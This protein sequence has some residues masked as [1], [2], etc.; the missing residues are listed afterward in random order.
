MMLKD[1]SA[2]NIQ[3]LLGY[4]VLIDTLSFDFYEEGVPWQ[5]YG[6]FCRHFIAPLLLMSN[7]DVRMG[8]ISQLF[9][10]GIPLDYAS[11]ILQNRGGIFAKLHINLHAKA[12]LRH[13][14]DGHYT[15]KTKKNSVLSKS[16]YISLAQGMLD[17]IE[18][19]T[20]PNHSTEWG[21][22]Y[23]SN[24]YTDIS[25]KGKKTIV[26]NFLD[27]CEKI[28]NV[29]DF[30]ANDGTYSRI[31]LSK[32]ANVVAFDIDSVAVERNYQEVKRKRENLLPLIF[33]MTTPSPSIGF[34]N[35]ERLNISERQKPDCVMMLAVIHHLAI[36]NNLP[37]NLIV[38]WLSSI[39]NYLIIEFVPKEDSQVKVLLATRIDIFPNYHEIHF[40]E[41]FK[42]K[43]NLLAKEYIPESK[44]TLYL[45]KLSN[46]D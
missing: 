38:D 36:S 13:N 30:G 16:A 8:K 22:Y 27:K 19:L 37:F 45:F 15:D 34:G 33:D 40:E 7:I 5:A 41:V 21:D 44:R 12:I 1:A 20:A 26:S 29:W 3:F 31:A 17:G 32:G 10:D 9:I 42:S 25:N 18:K 14:H 39:S 2:Y 4:A 46:T 11:S 23:C 28:R 43:F 24:N 35:S 6:Q